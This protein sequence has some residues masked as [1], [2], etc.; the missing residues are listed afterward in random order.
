[1]KDNDGPPLFSHVS[2][3]VV[4]L[5]KCRPVKV[6][7]RHNEENCCMELPVWSGDD[8]SV[9]AFVEPTSKKLT[10]TCNGFDLPFS[11]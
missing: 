6:E 3:E 5:Y 8:L 7:I 9:P 11:M 2:G 10:Y 1:M 4:I